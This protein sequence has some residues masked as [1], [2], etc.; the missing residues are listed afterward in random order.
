MTQQ[1]IS[2]HNKTQQTHNLND[3]AFFKSSLDILLSMKKVHPSKMQ[4]ENTERL[5]CLSTE[6]HEWCMHGFIVQLVR[7]PT[8]AHTDHLGGEVIGQHTYGSN[9]YFL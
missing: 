1:T 5:V 8:H 2:C 9:V 7:A 4:N 3:A 6:Q